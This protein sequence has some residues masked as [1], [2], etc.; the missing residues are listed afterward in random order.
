MNLDQSVFHPA[1]GEYPTA[2]VFDV[3]EVHNA[4]GIGPYARLVLNFVRPYV[5]TEVFRDASG[6][7]ID[8]GDRWHG[9]EG[10]E[11]NYEVVSHPER[12][13]PIHDVAAALI[14]HLSDSYEV[15]V[16]SELDPLR[17]GNDRI[18]GHKPMRIVRLSPIDTSSAPLTFVF[19]PFPSLTLQAG[20]MADFSYPSCGCDHCDEEANWNIEELER[21]VAAVV[22]GRLRETLSTEKPPWSGMEI[23]TLDGDEEDSE[24]GV[25]EHLTQPEVNIIRRRLDALS[26]A[27]WN[28]WS[29]R[30][31]SIPDE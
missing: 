6:E 1:F 19:W 15:Q 26:N 4:L 7:I 2:D 20:A 18:T 24:R 10:P 5:R 27:G 13:Q 11:D 31:V 29:E 3:R 14:K 16:S 25:E 21:I 17:P 9:E 30:K 12:F 8:Y 28:A 23:L 22:D